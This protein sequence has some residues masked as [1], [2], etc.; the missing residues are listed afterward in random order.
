MLM[1]QKIVNLYIYRTSYLFYAACGD[2]CMLEQASPC[3][4]IPSRKL[5]ANQRINEKYLISC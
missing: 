1:L 4:C 2:G 5:A 3:T